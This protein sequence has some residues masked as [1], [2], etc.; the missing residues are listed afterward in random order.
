MAEAFD[1]PGIIYQNLKDAGCDE[2]TTETCMAYVQAGNYRALLPE[3]L[4]WRKTLLDAVHA[5]QKQIDC[6]DYLIYRI[7]KKTT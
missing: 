3:L 6:L 7:Q 4:T 2:Q 5:G 1:T